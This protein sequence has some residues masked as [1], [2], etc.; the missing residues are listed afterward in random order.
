MITYKSVDIWIQYQIENANKIVTSDTFDK[1]KINYVGGCDISFDKT[2]PKRSCAYLTIEDY[3]TKEIVYE[4][5]EITVLD[6]PY[7]SGFLG[8]REIPTY[9][10]LFERLK[11]N[12]PDKYPDVVMVDGF[13]ILHQRSFGSASHLGYILDIPTIGV[14][15]TMMEIDGIDERTIK[16]QFRDNCTKKGEYIKIVG[17]SGKVYGSALKNSDDTQNPIYVSIGHKICLETASEIVNELSQYKI[18]KLI[19]FNR[20]Y[21]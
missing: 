13:G 12:D 21:I 14:G 8:F 2:N 15:K 5:H 17:K 9:K 7:I 3:H 19:Y 6:V 16:T 1:T 18:F 11:I 4:D 10:I 20:Y